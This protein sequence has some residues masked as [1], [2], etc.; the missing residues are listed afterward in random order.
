MITRSYDASVEEYRSQQRALSRQAREASS[1]TLSQRRGNRPALA[2]VTNSASNPASQLR[3]PA[4]GT[5][6]HAPD[7]QPHAAFGSVDAKHKHQPPPLQ[8]SLRH[9]TRGS[10]HT[11]LRLPHPSLIDAQKQHAASGNVDVKPEQLQAPSLRLCRD[12]VRDT[13]L[14]PLLLPNLPRFP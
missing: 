5:E 14:L 8:M 9:R 4:D 2:E 12:V 10:S 11:A 6:N 3:P 1:S 7:E 13:P